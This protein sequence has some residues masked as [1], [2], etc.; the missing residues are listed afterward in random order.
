VAAANRLALAASNRQNSR[1]ASDAAKGCPLAKSALIFGIAGQDGPLLAELLLQ[2]DYRVVGFGREQSIARNEPLRKLQ[3]RIQFIHGDVL[4]PDSIERIIADRPADEIYNLAAQS[5]A[6][7][8]WE[9]VLETAQVNA[10]SAHR[11]FEAVRTTRPAARVFQ[12]SSSE[13]Y[14]STTESPQRETTPFYPINPYAVAKV[15]AHRIARVYRDSF[16]SYIACGILFNHESRHRGMGFLSQKLTYGAACAKLGIRNSLL[17]N[18]QGEPMVKDGKLAIGDLEATRDWGYAGDTVK[19]MWLMLQQPQ[20][21]DFVIGTGTSRSVRDMCE[22]AYAAAGLDWHDHVISD[23][24]F[25]RRTENLAPVAD[26]SKARAQLGWSPATSFKD[27]LRDMVEAHI[28]RLENQRRP[29][30]ISVGAARSGRAAASSGPRRQPKSGMRFETIRK[31]RIC[32]HPSLHTVFDL[33][34]LASCGRFP[35]ADEPESPTGPLEVVQCA[36]CKLVQ[37]RHDFHG[38]D[39]FRHTYGY[40]SGLNETMKTHLSKLIAGLCERQHPLRPGDIVLDIGSNDGTSLGFYQAPGLVRVGIDP[41]I[42]RFEKYYA[43]GILT[44]AD[45]FTAANFRKLVPAGKARIVT[46]IAMFYD[47]ADPNA[48]VADIGKVLADDGLWCTEQSYLPTMI[49][50]ASFDTICHEHLEYYTLRGIMLL[51]A[52]NGL[53]VI[54]V[55]LNDVNGGSFQVVLGHANSPLQPNQAAIDSLLLKEEREGYG[56]GAP[57]ER[58]KSLVSDA[59]KSVMGFLTEAKSSGRLV[60]GYGA[61]TKGNTLL[62]YF[63]ITADLMP[64]IA[65][66]NAT[67]FGCRTPGTGIPIISEEQSRQQRPYAYFVLP[68]HFREGIIR[69]ERA[70][71]ESGGVLVFPMPRFEIVTKAIFGGT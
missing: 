28:E 49:D 2:K 42:E 61:S 51:A 33:G 48:F 69:R 45:F 22:A 56:S 17:L 32:G 26:C 1:V 25:V 57:F 24:R 41:T 14:G 36:S 8:S 50:N 59:R 58:L 54:D 10:M 19:A 47:L 30:G 66:V 23:S 71:L 53:R 65:E 70:F 68:W 62:Q 34:S 27:I 55:A 16:G 4:E 46:T 3:G 43:P 52:R 37:L 35:A 15:Y 63:G 39:L 40:R 11:L 31:C 5:H 64:V 13:M 60:H 44:L 18:E 67:K 7:K 12:A 9:L 21:D 6:G 29:A 38:D 20:A